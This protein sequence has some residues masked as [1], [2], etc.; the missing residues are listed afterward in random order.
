[1]NRE[2]RNFRTNGRRLRRLHSLAEDTEI[3]L[4]HFIGDGSL[5]REYGG[6][7]SER[8]HFFSA[9]LPFALC[10]NSSFVDLPIA[11]NLFVPS[12]SKC[13]SICSN[14]YVAISVE[15]SKYRNIRMPKNSGV[16]V[17]WENQT[18]MICVTARSSLIVAS[19]VVCKAG[20]S[21]FPH[22][23]RPIELYQQVWFRE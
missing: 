17:L 18:Q 21:G 3:I 2:H 4:C 16:C 11:V 9:F 20:C 22:D 14:R 10:E 5:W 15:F 1:M 23:S 19:G 6:T 12:L 7:S 13:C 8:R